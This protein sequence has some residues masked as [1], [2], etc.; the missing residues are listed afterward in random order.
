LADNY[1]VALDFGTWMLLGVPLVLVMLPLTWVLL[2]KVAF[3]SRGLDL[4]GARAMVGEELHAMGSMS[5]GER[6]VLVVF[7]V[8]A[9]L[10]MTRK[11]LVDWTG[12][13]ISDTT[14]ALTSAILLFALPASIEKGQF[15]LEWD[16]AKKVPW[17]VLLLFGGGLALAGAF[18]S[19]GL[20][21]AIGTWVAG[22]EGLD[23]ALI[24]LITIAAIVLLTELTSNTATTATFLPILAAVAIGLG[25]SPMMLAVPAALAASMAFMMPVATP[26]NAIV[27]SYEGLHIRDMI[28]AGLWLNLL[29]IAVIYGAMLFLAPLVLGL[30]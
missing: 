26:P 29:A 7:V 10:W 1:D 18:R 27:F 8:T 17:G 11:W 5:R 16:G 25:A 22:L 2:C 9:V 30:R 23:I 14:I 4:G 12:L 6:T 21:E 13:S 15:T 19:T 20:A 3:P 28:K 24:V